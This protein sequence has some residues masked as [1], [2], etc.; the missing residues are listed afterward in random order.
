[1]TRPQNG[2]AAAQHIYEMFALMTYAYMFLNDPELMADAVAANRLA[3]RG[4]LTPNE[5]KPE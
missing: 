5:G 4:Y 1:M 2:I 3:E